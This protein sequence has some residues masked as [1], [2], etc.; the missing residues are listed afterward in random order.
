MATE[1]ATKS[2]KPKSGAFPPNPQN[3]AKRKNWGTPK[4]GWKSHQIL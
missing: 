1:E 3:M 2:H 4:K